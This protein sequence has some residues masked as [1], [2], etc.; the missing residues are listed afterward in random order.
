M[1][2]NPIASTVT[3]CLSFNHHFKNKHALL[4]VT[5][6]AVNT[7]NY[8]QWYPIVIFLNPDSKQG[9]KL[10]RQRVMP[11]SSRSARKLYLQALKL[12]K[13]CSNLFTGG[14]YSR[15]TH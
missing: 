12:R 4:D 11:H 5:P 13:T 3:C 7:L 9:V 10:M 8:T 15:Q 6:K 1:T 2:A 14:C